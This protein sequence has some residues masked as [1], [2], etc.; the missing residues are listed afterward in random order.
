MITEGRYDEAGAGIEGHSGKIGSVT[1]FSS[2]EL[3]P[4]AEGRADEECSA[5]NEDFGVFPDLLPFG[6]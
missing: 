2:G 6:T 1:E 5:R 4:V 3:G